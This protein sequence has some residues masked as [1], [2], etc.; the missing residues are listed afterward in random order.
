MTQEHR[1]VSPE[2]LPDH[3]KLLLESPL[4]LKFAIQTVLKGFKW[5]IRRKRTIKPHR[6]HL[7]SVCEFLFCCRCWKKGWKE[8]KHGSDYENIFFVFHLLGSSHVQSERGK[9]FSFIKK[10][11]C[12]LTRWR[13]VFFLPAVSDAFEF[14][15]VFNSRWSVTFIII[16]FKKTFSS[17]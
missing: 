10:N 14:M 16:L 2:T 15:R 17:K 1:Q 11:Y 13:Y 9:A 6:A 7:H 8:E 3:I 5:N 12:N 4:V